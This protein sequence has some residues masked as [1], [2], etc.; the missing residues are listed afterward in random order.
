VGAGGE[1]SAST[2]SNDVEDEFIHGYELSASDSLLGWLF[3]VVGLPEIDVI[4]IVSRFL[5]IGVGD[6]ISLC[7]INLCLGIS[8]E[9]LESNCSLGEYEWEFNGP[10]EWMPFPNVHEAAI[11][12][13]LEPYA[14]VLGW[15]ACAIL[16]NPD[17][18]GLLTDGDVGW[19][20]ETIALLVSEFTAWAILEDDAILGNLAMSEPV[21]LEALASRAIGLGKPILLSDHGFNLGQ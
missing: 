12:P 4:I 11:V 2:G 13:I 16:V 9:G 10:R 8:S 15:K 1:G 21:F 14:M 7:T 6:T 19:I 17:D 5:I 3:I 20:P 18:H